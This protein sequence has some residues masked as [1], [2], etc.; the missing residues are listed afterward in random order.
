MFHEFAV[1][2]ALCDNFKDARYLL[3]RFGYHYGRLIAEFPKDW[4]S[5]AYSAF[6]GGDLDKSR[7]EILLKALKARDAF[8]RGRSAR[9]KPGDPWL[10]QAEAE[11]GLMPFRAI[12]ADGNPRGH[13]DVLDGRNITEED[14]RWSVPQDR[15]VP[16][17][18]A[19]LA[20]AAGWLLRQSRQ[21][22]FIDP[23]FDAGKSEKMEPMRAYLQMIAERL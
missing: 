19:Q 22:I 3:E 12:V 6:N 7:L 2:P 1:D 21:V 20:S 11:H 18:A 14:S 5:R 15:L 4:L 13:A 10:I 8:T 9:W 23:Y 16:R 17:E